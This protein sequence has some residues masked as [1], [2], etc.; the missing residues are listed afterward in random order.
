MT[1]RERL[2][3]PFRGQKPDQPAWLAD[4]GYWYRW[5]EATGNLGSE[6]AGDDGYLRLHED[7]GVCAHYGL[8][9]AAFT[10]RLVMPPSF[11]NSPVS[12]KSGIARS[13]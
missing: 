5:A 2:L 8:G 4:L 11:I 3:A 7:L 13:P 6:Y 1:P 12:M 10:S 9:R